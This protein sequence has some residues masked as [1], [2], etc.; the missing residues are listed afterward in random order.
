MTGHNAANLAPSIAALV[1]MLTGAVGEV[2]GMMALG[3]LLVGALGMVRLYGMFDRW[4]DRWALSELT[5]AATL[6]WYG[7]GACVG[8]LWGD[9]WA[10]GMVEGRDYLALFQAGVFVLIAGNMMLVLAPIEHRLWAPAIDS[11]SRPGPPVPLAVI[12]ALVLLWMLLFNLL[13]DGR[14]GYRGFGELPGLGVQG[15]PV[16]ESLVLEISL[17]LSGYF[18][19]LLGKRREG[20]RLPL[21]WLAVA[22]APLLWLILI[23][24]GRRELFAH[25]VAFLI[26]FL[27]ARQLRLGARPILL[28]SI[29]ALPLLF[30]GTMIFQVQRFGDSGLAL[31][32]TESNLV[33]RVG[34]AVDELDDTWGAVLDSQVEQFPSRVFVI[35]YLKELMDSTDAKQFGFGRELAAE[36]VLAVPSVLYPDKVATIAALG[37]VGEM[38]NPDFGLPDLS[39]YP[40]SVLSAAYMDFG[41]L[42]AAIAPCLVLLAGVAA[43]TL[44]RVVRNEL[45]RVVLVSIIVVEYLFIEGRFVSDTLATARVVLLL[46]P[47]SVLLSLGGRGS[48]S[49]APLEGTVCR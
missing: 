2:A 29:V 11:L 28:F 6:L 3:F 49:R 43:A 18:G 44:A 26:V 39:D 25:A 36:L 24:Q 17:A 16:L 48:A 10:I 30:A 40:E 15:L 35:G 34:R 38:R 42:G 21:I 8:L 20:S 37:G 9:V 23:G 31:E 46:A 14:I 12:G 5:G 41:W 1:L 13:L 47:L 22:Y 32:M 7:T 4:S 45:F 19:W 27:W 33:E